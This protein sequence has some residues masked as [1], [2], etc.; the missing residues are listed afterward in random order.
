ML[1]C[2]KVI[3]LKRLS[4]IDEMKTF[5]ETLRKNDLIVSSHSVL[6]SGFILMEF[7]V[8]KIHKCEVYTLYGI[9]IGLLGAEIKMIFLFGPRSSSFET[10]YIYH[11]NHVIVI[12][13]ATLTLRSG[14]HMTLDR[15]HGLCLYIGSTLCIHIVS[16][17]NGNYCWCC[18]VWRP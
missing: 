4:L 2:T 12:H 16:H 18:A 14:K 15:C 3:C 9:T 5:I 7:C 10:Q 8:H 1:P 6:E 17:G 13:V 11:C